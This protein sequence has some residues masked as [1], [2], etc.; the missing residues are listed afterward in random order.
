MKSLFYSLS[1]IALLLVTGCESAGPFQGE[2]STP[3]KFQPGKPDQLMCL[4]CHRIKTRRDRK[5]IA[6]ARETLRRK[7]LTAIL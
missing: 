3:N 1:S 2:H 5:N 4:P 7:R 6:K